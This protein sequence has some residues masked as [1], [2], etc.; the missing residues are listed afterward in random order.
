[1]RKFGGNLGVY[2]EK[3]ESGR[4]EDIDFIFQDLSSV[5]SLVTTRNIDFA[6]S[7]V[8]TQKGLERIKYYLFNGSLIQRN[9]ASLFFNRRGDWEYVLEAYRKGLIDEIQ[10]YSR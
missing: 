3:A 4:S 1:M 8:T 7:L 9:Y 6:L 5:S 10:A 2:I